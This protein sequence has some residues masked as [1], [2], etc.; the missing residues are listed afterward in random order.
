[1]RALR[2][3]RA[4]DDRVI[5][6]V[7]REVASAPDPS[8]R[9]ER[10]FAAMDR[11]T[12]LAAERGPR[13]ACAAGC[14]WCCH[15]HVEAT[16]AEVEA[17]AALVTR[18]FAPAARDALVDSLAARVAAFG[19]ASAEGRWAARAPCAL[20]DASGRCSIY[21]ARPLRC[22]AFHSLDAGICEAAFLGASDAPPP[23]SASFER[24]ATAVEHG[25]D[26]ALGPDATP[27]LLEPALLAA[28]R[29]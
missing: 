23:T 18:T 10:A 22:R 5:G 26:R 21:A 24:A 1:M 13:P 4:R 6:A 14:S 11:E 9:A 15:V 2:V 20:L 25:F 8:S 3:L 19:A 16:G 12:A 17:A 27:V 29:P 28:L 7:E